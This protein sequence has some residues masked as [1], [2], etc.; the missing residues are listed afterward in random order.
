MR[1]CVFTLAKSS[2]RSTCYFDYPP[3]SQKSGLIS[4]LPLLLPVDEPTLHLEQ[5]IHGWMAFRFV[6]P[7]SR[8]LL[9]LS[10]TISK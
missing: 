7:P 9:N 4:N 3:N 2:D 10:C 6:Y 1:K 8:D 5:F